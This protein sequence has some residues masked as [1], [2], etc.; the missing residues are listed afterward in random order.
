MNA[1]A[2][3]STSFSLRQA[4]FEA[5]FVLLGVGSALMATAWWQGRQQAEQISVTL[6]A[7]EAE[8][9]TNIESAEASRA[10]HQEKLTMLRSW[11]KD[12][13]PEPHDFPQGFIR[14]AQ[15]LRAAWEAARESGTLT[16]LDYQLLLTL[17]KTYAAQE[18]YEDQARMAGELIY[19]ALLDRGMPGLLAGY[20]NLAAIIGTFAYREAQL[21]E[22]YEETLTVL[23][24]AV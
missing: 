21:I 14:S 18:R 6:A 24:A 12:E 4:F 15:V 16:N 5:F 19:A 1:P 22:R 20:R 7:I 3:P 9:R 17:S 23:A 11:S 10:Y 2:T 13:A 8:L